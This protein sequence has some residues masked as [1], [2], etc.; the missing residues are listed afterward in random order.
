MNWADFKRDA[1]LIGGE[2]VGA[3]GGGTIDVTNPATG[4]VIGTVPNAGTDETR[5]AIAA[6][7]KA[8]ETFSRTTADERA[9]LLRRLHA[10]IMDNQRA[11]AELLTIEQG[12]PLAESM[13][14]VGASAAYVLWFSEEARRVYGDVIPSPW[15][16]RR[17]LVTKQAVGV[18]AAI[19]PWNFPSSMA[20]R[21]IGPALATGCTS[22]MKPATQTPYSGLAWGVLCEQAGYPKGV[23]N[24]LTGSAS[25]IGGEMTSNPTV[26]K[27]TFTGSTPIGKMLIKQAADTVKRVSMELG[28]NAPFLIFDDAD[29]DKA[30]EGAIGSKYRNSGQTCVCAN[31]FY[32]QAGI[33]DAFV[34]K[35]AAASA[36]LKV[37]P[38]LEEGVVQGPLIDDKAVAKTAS[39][40]ADALAKGGKLVTGG[41]RHD[42]GGQ[43]FE[44]TVIADATSE[45]NFAREEIF[46]P[47]APVFRFET[48]EEAVRLAND[49]EFGLACYFYTRDLARAFRVSENLRYGQVGINAGVITTEVAPFG[50]VK[51]SGIGREGSKYGI[52]EY[53]DVKYVCVGGL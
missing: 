45:M 42:L 8:F 6:A 37:G 22:V 21:K 26:R 39:F 14:E 53:L 48:E 13:G 12:K 49:T 11:L 34:E 27:I 33:Y 20:A 47:V 31:R 35:L 9:K 23:V 18:V 3:D 19:T 25:A 40:V 52:E 36:K 29:L 2:W 41:K 4:E 44:P 38:G 32:A 16:E 7:E 1:N 50:G 46:G 43:F 30:V 51:E 10:A 28:G 17:I 15:G 24:I 5:R